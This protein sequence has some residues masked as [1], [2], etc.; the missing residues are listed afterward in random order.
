[1][2]LQKKP[3]T[4]AI[5][6]P[7]AHAAAEG[8]LDAWLPRLIEANEILTGALVRIRDTHLRGAAPDNPVLVEIVTALETAAQ[9]QSAFSRS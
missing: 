4:K 9:V 2:D 5:G 3:P 7:D 8:T 6:F 1:M